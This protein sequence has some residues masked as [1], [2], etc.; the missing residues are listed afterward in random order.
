MSLD[1]YPTAENNPQKTEFHNSGRSNCSIGGYEVMVI[2]IMT[3]VMGL[4]IDIL[5]MEMENVHED[6][7][8][9]LVSRLVGVA[10]MGEVVAMIVII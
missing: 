9:F 8:L 6:E 2:G 10:V 1:G 5:Q 3:T 7:E 4:L